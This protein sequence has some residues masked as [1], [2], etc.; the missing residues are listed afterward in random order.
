MTGMPGPRLPD[1][2]MPR[3]LQRPGPNTCS[4][5][6]FWGILA[7]RIAPDGSGAPVCIA[8]PPRNIAYQNPKVD[9]AGNVIGVETRVLPEYPP[10]KPHW[11]CGRWAPKIEIATSLPSR[12]PQMGSI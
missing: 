10:T 9:D 5:C 4:S 8:E 2:M 7:E 12:N 11:S 3:V 1:S 6:K